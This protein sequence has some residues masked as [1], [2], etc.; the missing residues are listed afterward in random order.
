MT[1]EL[2]A[3]G[4]VLASGVY[5]FDPQRLITVHPRLP[6]IDAHV[7]WVSQIK[8]FTEALKL[9]ETKVGTTYLQFELPPLTSKSQLMK[10]AVPDEP[11]IIT[12]LPLNLQDLNVPL[13]LS[14]T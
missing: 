4:C 7:N 11:K 12:E 2:V 8:T 13:V 5:G 14:V 10:A 3:V 6:V 1:V 9:T